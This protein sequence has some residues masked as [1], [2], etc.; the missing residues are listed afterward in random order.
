[1]LMAI[2][3]SVALLAALAHHARGRGPLARWS[4]GAGVAGA[5]VLTLGALLTA[6]WRAE[7]NLAWL[8]QGASCRPPAGLERLGCFTVEQYRAD[9]IR[10]VQQ[11]TGADEPIFVGLGRH[12][13]IFVNDVTFYFLAARRSATRWHHMDPGLQTSAPIQRE[14]V[15]ELGA[16]R[17]RFVLL[18]SRW[19]GEKEPNDSAVS[20]GVTILDDYIRGRFAPVAAFGTMAVLQDREQRARP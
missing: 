7:P 10:Y 15:A 20:S 5:A 18:E 2:V 11:R 1:M 8:A 19:D 12:D 16:E 3:S 4:A 14:V 13:K 9:A 17:P 6:M